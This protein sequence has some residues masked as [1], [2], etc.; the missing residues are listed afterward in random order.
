[1]LKI[2][3]IVLFDEKQVEVHDCLSIWVVAIHGRYASFIWLLRLFWDRKESIFDACSINDWCGRWLRAISIFVRHIHRYNE[4]S[5]M[6]RQRL[7]DLISAIGC[8]DIYDAMLTMYVV[9]PMWIRFYVVICICWWASW[10]KILKWKWRD[11][12]S[13]YWIYEVMVE[14]PLVTSE[15][16]SW[17]LVQD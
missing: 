5:I 16:F 15:V 3:G 6:F 1:M 4:I 7:Y 11:Q 13:I 9:P 14:L 2:G 8:V 10:S 17:S 12:K